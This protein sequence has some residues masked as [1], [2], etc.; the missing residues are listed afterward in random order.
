MVRPSRTFAALAA[1]PPAP[2]AWTLW[3]RPLLLTLLLGCFVSLVASGTLTVRLVVLPAVYWSFVALAQ[4]L[5][6]AA[7]RWRRTDH[8]PLST[9]VDVF[10]TGLGPWMLLLLGLASALA[11]PTPAYGWGRFRVWAGV[12]LA[13]IVWS[14]YIDFWFFRI[15]LGASRAGA[16]RD[17]IVNRLMTWTIVFGIFAVPGSMPWSVVR[18]VIEAVRELTR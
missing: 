2:G 9:A 5:V 15:V 6:L 13:V 12:G 7:M 16:V 14:A 8:L 17:V 1:N 11:F 4:V 3:R 18:E 10:L